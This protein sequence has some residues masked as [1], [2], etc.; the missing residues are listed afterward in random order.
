MPFIGAEFDRRQGKLH[1]L[2][3]VWFW[4]IRPI[5]HSTCENEWEIIKLRDGWK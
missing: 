2:T 4:R 3:C 5:I 1:R